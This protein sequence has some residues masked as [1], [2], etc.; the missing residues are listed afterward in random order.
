M[1]SFIWGGIVIFFF[2]FRLP[3]IDNRDTP[4]FTKKS[5]PI[6]YKIM[7]KYTQY[8]VGGDKL[9]CVCVW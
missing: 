3:V 1:G 7:C 8:W 2:R 6:G 4:K 5:K 9:C